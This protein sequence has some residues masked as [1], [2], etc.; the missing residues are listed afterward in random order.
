[1]AEYLVQDTSLTAVADAIREK[2]GT[3]APLS[4]P[5]GMAKA[6]REIPSGGTDISLGLTAATVDQTIKV[7]AVDTDGK[8]T[9]WEA[10]DMA[11]VETEVVVLSEDVNAVAF[12][13]KGC[14]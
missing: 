4:F 3:T 8:P 10:V 2:G 11:E 9:A 14:D 6:V 12:D 13:L 1:M 7:K 5:D